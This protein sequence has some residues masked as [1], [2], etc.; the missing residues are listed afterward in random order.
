MEINEPYRY[1]VWLFDVALE[2]E[3]RSAYDGFASWLE[4]VLLSISLL[5]PLVIC[6]TTVCVTKPC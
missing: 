4:N 6:L 3:T 5:L 2:A 1:L